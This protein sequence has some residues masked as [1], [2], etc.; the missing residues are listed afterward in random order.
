MASKEGTRSERGL[1]WRLGGFAAGVVAVGLATGCAGGE[2]A[3][4]TSTAA[5]THASSEQSPTS[6]TTPGTTTANRVATLVFDALG[7]GSSII[8]V[9]PG[10]SDSEADKKANGTFNNGDT[11]AGECFDE[12]R[13]VHS[14]PELGERDVRSNIWFRFHGPSGQ[15]YFA[16]AV[17]VQD[18]A[19]LQAQLSH[20]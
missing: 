10:P 20:C 18:P 2:P 15:E 13:D 16:T 5:P 7:G 6:R 4:A 12:G 8:K 11:A 3:S 19:A 1:G 9:Y 14:H 17:Y